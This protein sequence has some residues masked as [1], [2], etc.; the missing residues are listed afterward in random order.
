MDTFVTSLYGLAEHCESRALHNDMVRDQIV[1]GLQETQ[2]S[3]KLLLDA[4]LAL[5]KTMTK[6]QQSKA[7]KQRQ[8]V[9]QASGEVPP[10]VDALY[11]R[12]AEGNTSGKDPPTGVFLHRA[13]QGVFPPPPQKFIET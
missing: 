4:G 13:Q 2:L 9:I 1:V 3:E 10:N 8:A 6:A 7:V 11:G 5:E 12:R